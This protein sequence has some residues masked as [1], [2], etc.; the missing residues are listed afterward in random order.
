MKKPATHSASQAQMQALAEFRYTLRKF[1]YFSEQ[2][3][4][5][6]GLTAQQHQFLLQIAGAPAGAVTAV[7]YLAERLVL[8]HH[9]VVELGDR[10]EQ[11]GLIVRKRD[12][13]NRRQVVLEL[14]AAGKQILTEL[15][16]DHA[17]ELNELGPLL[18]RALKK[19]IVPRSARASHPQERKA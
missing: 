8:R 6:A 11:A 2:A 1:L 16:A 18:I 13:E 15:S 5:Q 17:R 12:Q 14:T 19:S 4:K 9:S 10:C 7:R 3:A